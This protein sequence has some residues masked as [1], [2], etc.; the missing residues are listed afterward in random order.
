MKE[1]PEFAPDLHKFMEYY[2][3]TTVKLLD[4]YEELDKQPV[5]GEISQMGRVRL[6]KRW[7]R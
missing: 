4:A 2:L 6:R 7:I 1:H 3:P 5:Q